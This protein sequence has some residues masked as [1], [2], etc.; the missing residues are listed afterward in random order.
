MRAIATASLALT[1]C[2]CGP[3]L[4]T[5][6]RE[7]H[8]P[9]AVCQAY[10]SG[11]DAVRAAAPVLGAQGAPRWRLRRIVPEDLPGLDEALAA[12]L[13]ESYV[14]VE[15]ETRVDP[16]SGFEPIYAFDDVDG[17]EPLESLQALTSVV[18]GEATPGPHDEQVDV[19]VPGSKDAPLWAV[20]TAGLSLLVKPLWTTRTRTDEVYPTSAELERAAPRAAAIAKALAGVARFPSTSWFALPKKNGNVA[21]LYVYTHLEAKADTCRENLDVYFAPIEIALSDRQR[22]P[23]GQAFQRLEW[24]ALVMPWRR[25]VTN[26]AVLPAH[27]RSGNLPRWWSGVLEKREPLAPVPKPSAR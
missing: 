17:G 11:D 21:R 9:E 14:L 22:W 20:A 2:A 25:V 3:S 13:F 12:L 26:G 4:Q 18:T 8:Y 5:L 6:V 27:P 16:V 10:H 7:H 23:A 19:L 15:V 1:T 24:E